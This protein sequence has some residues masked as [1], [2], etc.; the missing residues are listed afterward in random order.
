MIYNYRELD[1]YPSDQDMKNNGVFSIFDN[2]LV[3][4]TDN[5]YTQVPHQNFV[6]LA[7]WLLDQK[8]PDQYIYAVLHYTNIKDG[9][10]YVYHRNFQVFK[11]SSRVWRGKTKTPDWFVQFCTEMQKVALGGISQ[12]SKDKLINL[13]QDKLPT[14]KPVLKKKDKLKHLSIKTNK[15]L[16]TS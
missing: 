1:D 3:W 12:S 8:F 9:S 10:H 6:E 16:H 5:N 7:H 2:I 14:T 15:T 11:L 13:I 4:V